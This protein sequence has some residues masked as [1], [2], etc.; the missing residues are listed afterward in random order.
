MPRKRKPPLV[1]VIWLDAK[2]YNEEWQINEISQRALFA[3][4]HTSGYLVFQDEERTVLAGTFDPATSADAEDGVADT[5]VLPTGWV[6]E[7]IQQRRKGV[8]RGTHTVLQQ[9]GKETPVSNDGDRWKP[10]VEQGN[11]DEVGTPPGEG[12]KG[13]PRDDAEG[14]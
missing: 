13:V 5:T 6:V 10:G 3:R 14:S 9:G 4:R 11:P 12:R 2:T 1:E 7:I 8:R